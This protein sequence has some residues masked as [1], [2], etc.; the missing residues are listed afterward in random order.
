[1]AG[2]AISRRTGVSAIFVTGN[3]IDLNMCA[4]QWKVGILMVKF[5]RLPSIDGVANSTIMIEL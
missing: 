4:G 3:A 1:V 5:G 2:V